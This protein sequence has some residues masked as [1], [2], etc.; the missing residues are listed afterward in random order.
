M[1]R[2][3]GQEIGAATA[4]SSAQ[5]PEPHSQ[6]GPMLDRFRKPLLLGALACCLTFSFA[7]FAQVVDPCWYGC[8][9]AGCPQCGDQGGPLTK[10]EKERY[11]KSMSSA[12]MACRKACQKNEGRRRGD[13]HTHFRADSQ[14]DK[15]QICLQKSRALFIKCKSGC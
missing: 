7:L 9:K 10:L 1:C 12:H 5:E 6:G 15:H 3:R 8:P 4:I 11:S 14:P 13:C 2:Q